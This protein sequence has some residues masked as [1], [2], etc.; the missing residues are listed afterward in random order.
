MKNLISFSNLILSA[1]LP[2]NKMMVIMPKAQI[3]MDFTQEVNNNSRKKLPYNRDHHVSIVEEI[4]TASI[5]QQLMDCLVSN[6]KTC[7]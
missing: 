1:L 6:F 5:K 3:I 2:R 4:L 7:L